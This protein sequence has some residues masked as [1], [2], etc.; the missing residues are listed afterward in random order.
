[1]N[2]RDLYSRGH[3]FHRVAKMLRE[4]PNDELRFMC[5]FAAC[6][7]SE[8]RFAEAEHR[9]DIPGNDGFVQT[10]PLDS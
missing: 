10:A 7:W 3:H 6:Y 4:M 1:M 8:E 2:R 5:L 9:G